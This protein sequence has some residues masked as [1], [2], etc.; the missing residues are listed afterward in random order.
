M[1]IFLAKGTILY[2]NTFE[3]NLTTE[4]IL[5]KKITHIFLDAGHGGKD[6]GASCYSLIEK[7]LTLQAALEL[8]K[9]LN[10]ILPQKKIL[11]TRTR[12]EYISLED[13]CNF[14]NKIIVSQKNTTGIFISLHLNSWFSPNIRGL[15]LFYPKY[16]KS[17]QIQKIKDSL[18]NHYDDKDKNPPPIKKIFSVL[19]NQSHHQN[20][21]L[22]SKFL[23][24]SIHSNGDYFFRQAKPE[25]FY[26]LK[27]PKMISVLIE[28]GFISNYKDMYIL[29]EKNSRKKL[30][31]SLSKIIA[32]FI[33]HL[34]G[35]GSSLLGI[36]FID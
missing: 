4:T 30:F 28:L 5:H 16:K 9:L 8:K 33:N 6:N 22:F 26:V 11:L 2:A 32:N 31:S 3:S 12:D 14:A 34:Q 10:L 13:R 36:T 35:S 17:H 25:F 24:T 20:S 27:T 23:K 19:E 18:N 29:L 1:K 7:E 21:L 15:E